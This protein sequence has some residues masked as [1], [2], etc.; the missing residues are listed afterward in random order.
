MMMRVNDVTIRRMAGATLS[1]VRSATIWSA[2]ETWAGEFAPLASM[3]ILGSAISCA[4]TDAAPMRSAGR[5]TPRIR[6]IRRLVALLTVGSRVEPEPAE[7]LARAR[8][9]LAER[10][11]RRGRAVDGGAVEHAREI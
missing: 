10:G 5:I 9:H 1:T 3:V 2:V 4:A 7:A 11:I 6:R 8:E